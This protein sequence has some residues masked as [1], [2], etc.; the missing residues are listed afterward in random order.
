MPRLAQETIDKLVEFISRSDINKAQFENYM[1]KQIGAYI[2]NVV[3][4]DK[5][6]KKK[7]IYKALTN[8]KDANKPQLTS[9]KVGDTSKDGFII[10]TDLKEQLLPAMEEFTTQKRMEVAKNVFENIDAKLNY[11]DARNKGDSE[12]FSGNNKS[13]F[14]DIQDSA[15]Y[16]SEHYLTLDE[17]AKR[18][19]CINT[20]RY[21]TNA[22]EKKLNEKNNKY[23][24]KSI[25]KDEIVEGEIDRSIQ[26]IGE[27]AKDEKITNYVSL[28]KLSQKFIAENNDPELGYTNT[29]MGVLKLAL[30]DDCSL[31]TLKEIT[32]FGGVMQHLTIM[33]DK[34]V[35][36]HNNSG[37][38]RIYNSQ[39]NF[40]LKKIIS[41]IICLQSSA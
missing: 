1:I 37:V 41:F 35:I 12:N 40:K 7:V 25:N 36:C 15:H 23:V 14:E 20:S 16:Y 30:N 28:R 2:D 32:D 18:D 13:L 38:L 10:A 24:D 19:A 6:T 21:F 4:A 31:K 33:N 3:N 5:T 22:A 8:K 34:Y 39:E 27:Y 17:K 9:F 29:P 11:I 26:K